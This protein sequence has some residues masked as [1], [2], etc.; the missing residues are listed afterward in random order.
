MIEWR[1]AVL[2]L[3]LSLCLG[4]APST[5]PRGGFVNYPEKR[6]VPGVKFAI[7]DGEVY[8][9]DYFKPDDSVDVVVWFLG[10]SWAVEQEFYDAHKNAIL[11]IA[12]DHLLQSNFPGPQ[13][14]KNLLGN[15]QLGLKKKGVVADKPVGKICL[16]SFSNGYTVIRQLLTF[17]DVMTHVT[18]VVLCDSLYAK[19]IAGENSEIDD[20]Q[21]APFL[22]YARKAAAGEKNFFFS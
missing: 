20:L 2:G 5:Q 17:D 15:L 22:D 4:A 16:A 8:V 14:F 3:I 7:S 1:H 13:H 9:P 21:M 18:D 12:N 11:F 19:R 10:A 6:D